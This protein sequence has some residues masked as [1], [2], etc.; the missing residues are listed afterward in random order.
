MIK[1]NVQYMEKNKRPQ[2]LAFHQPLQTDKTKTTLSDKYWPL[3][4]HTS[5]GIGQICKTQ[6]ISVT[7]L[8]KTDKIYHEPK[9]KKEKTCSDKGDSISEIFKDHTKRF[10]LWAHITEY[11]LTFGTYNTLL[12]LLIGITKRI[13]H[14]TIHR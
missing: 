4:K 10:K 6:T 9:K 12:N 13:Y 5:F 8:S 1:S 14:K 3:E 2:S 11:L 7:D